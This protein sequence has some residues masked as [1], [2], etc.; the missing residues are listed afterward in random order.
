MLDVGA[1]GYYEW[2]EREVSPRRQRHEEIAR[3]AKEVHVMSHGIYGY[4]KVHA[5]LQVRGV[6]SSPET[7]R[8]MMRENGLKSRVKRRFV[9]TTDSDHEMPI[10]ENILD[11]DFSAVAPNHKWV[12]DITYIRTGEGWLYLAVVM[13]LFSRRIVGWEMKNRI[14]TNLVSSALKMAVY[15]RRGTDGLLHHSDRGSQYASEEYRDILEREKISCSMSRRGNC[16][17][18]ACMESFFRSLKTEWVY[19]KK[20]SN[21]EEAAQDIFKYIEIFYNR[22]RRHASLDYLTPVEFE[23]RHKTNQTERAA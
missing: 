14:D 18:N 22:Q 9:N 16:W 4:R 8:R 10:A 20:Y 11:R 17:D 13:D 19:G 12:A 7:I 23:T 21:R 1:S 15:Q 3:E 6:A 5:D 2:L